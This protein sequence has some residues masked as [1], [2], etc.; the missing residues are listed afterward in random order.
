ML[1]LRK[2]EAPT[3]HSPLYEQLL[4]P[5]RTFIGAFRKTG[6]AI[7]AARKIHSDQESSLKCV[8]HRHTMQGRLEN[9]LMLF[10]FYSVFTRSWPCARKIMS[11]TSAG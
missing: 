6:Q 7:L 11:F 3:K 9:D 2:L 1:Y 4:T 10:L 8:W 5:V